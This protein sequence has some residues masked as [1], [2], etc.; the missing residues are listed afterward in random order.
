MAHVKMRP[1]S[2]IIHDLEVE[3]DELTARAISL[4]A[5]LDMQIAENVRQR[6]ANAQVARERDYYK[7]FGV[8]IATRLLAVQEAITATVQA[9][10]LAG[11]KPLPVSYKAIAAEQPDATVAA[12]GKT[13]G[14]ENR[15]PDQEPDG[16]G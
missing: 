12:L 2:Q 8:E 10:D 13:F 6:E 16:R 11:Y 14:A 3:V 9:A 7:A 15:Q 5:S 4:Q 1:T